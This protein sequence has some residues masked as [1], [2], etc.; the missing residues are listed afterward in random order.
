MAGHQWQEELLAHQDSNRHQLLGGGGLH[1]VDLVS[2]LVAG[3][4]QPATLDQGP[5]YGQIA[6]V[7]SLCWLP[8]SSAAIRNG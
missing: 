6:G 8:C 7:D 1:N 5:L 2:R 3:I 4:I